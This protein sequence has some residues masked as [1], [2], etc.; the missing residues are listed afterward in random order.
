MGRNRLFAMDHSSQPSTFQHQQVRVV[1]PNRTQHGNH[2]ANAYD[3][4]DRQPR[5]RQFTPTPNSTFHQQSETTTA[6]AVPAVKILAKSNNK[7]QGHSSTVASAAVSNATAAQG[8]TIA[9]AAKTPTIVANNRQS[10]A[11]IVPRPVDA[12]STSRPTVIQNN[13]TTAHHQS[14]KPSI[15]NSVSILEKQLARMHIVPADHRERDILNN[16]TKMLDGEF[17]FQDTNVLERSLLSDTLPANQSSSTPSGQSFCVV[18]AVGLDGVGKSGLLNLIANRNVFKTHRNVS[19][20]LRNT[21]AS[22]KSTSGHDNPLSHVTSGVDLHITSER[23]FLL[24]T[25]VQFYH[26]QL[27]FKILIIFLFTASSKCIYS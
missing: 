16:C 15:S 20:E 11:G 3:N 8:N 22:S 5:S 2:N 23:L 27:L 12:V 24:D 9:Q 19:D 7:P 13:A 21:N 25:Q 18:G 26:S 6:T 4:F 17:N 14:G 1:K 10:V